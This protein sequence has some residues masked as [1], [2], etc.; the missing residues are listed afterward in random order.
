[1]FRYIHD[2]FS[3]DIFTFGDFVEHIYP[4][5]DLDKEGP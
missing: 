2:V 4:V 1:M 3:H 5:P